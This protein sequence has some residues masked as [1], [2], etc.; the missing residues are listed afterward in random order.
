[1]CAV[2]CGACLSDSPIAG[3]LISLLPLTSAIASSFR[4]KL[5]PSFHAPPS[6][7]C[8]PPIQ[9]PSPTLRFLILTTTLALERHSPFDSH[10]PSIPPDPTPPNQAPLSVQTLSRK[11]PVHDV[12]LKERSGAQRLLG[13]RPVNG[14]SSPRSPS[15]RFPSCR[16]TLRRLKVRLTSLPGTRRPLGASQTQSRSRPRSLLR[17]P[18]FPLRHTASTGVPPSSTSP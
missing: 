2:C 15:R 18:R 7:P 16:S 17:L 1:M 8:S 12:Q 14:A 11:F 6:P 9:P 10:R 4:P 5:S 3:R 13:R